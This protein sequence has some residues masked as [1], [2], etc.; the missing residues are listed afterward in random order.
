MIFH[1]V[2]PHKQRLLALS[3]EELGGVLPE[4]PPGI[5]HNGIFG[6]NGFLGLLGGATRLSE[7]RKQ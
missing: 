2:L 1:G 3:P 4:L 6:M 7:G 5:T